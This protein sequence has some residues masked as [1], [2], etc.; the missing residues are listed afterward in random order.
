MV[1]YRVN[2]V[3]FFIHHEDLRRRAQP[4]WE[5]RE[6]TRHDQDVL[7]RMLRLVGRGLVAKAGVPVRVDSAPT[8]SL[9][10]HPATW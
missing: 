3:E 2:P 7:W 6:L 4:G 9:D 10:R 8:P 1:Y 5:P